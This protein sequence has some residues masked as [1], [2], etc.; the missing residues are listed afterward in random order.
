MYRRQNPAGFY[1]EI[2]KL[3]LKCLW[4]APGSRAAKP[5]LRWKNTVVGFTL[6]ISELTINLR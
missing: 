1:A 2:D 3:I 4:K 5:S 6:L